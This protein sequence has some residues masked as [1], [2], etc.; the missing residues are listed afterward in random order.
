MGNL[1]GTASPGPIAD[2]VID[3]RYGMHWV[4]VSGLA[5]PE[6]LPTSIAAFTIDSPRIG[7]RFHGTGVEVNGWVVGR[8][9]P[10]QGIRAEREGGLGTLYPLDVQRDDVGADYPAFAHAGSSGFTAWSR[11]DVGT[12]DWHLAV[13]AVLANGST[14]TLAEI[15]GKAGISACDPRTDA[16]A[17]TAPDFIIVGA[18]RGG[19]TSLHAYLSAHPLVRTPSTKELHFFTDRFER[20]HSWYLS[21]FPA[22]LPPGI[23]TGEATPYALFHPL[24]PERARQIAPEAKLIALLRN[25]VDRAYSHYLL[26]RSRGFEPLEFSAALDAE[27]GRLAGEEAAILRCPTYLGAA[28][29]RYSYLARGDYAPQ[30]ERWLAHFPRDQMLVLRSE[31]LY[32]Q[33]RET[34]A[35]VAVFL[36]IES[37]LDTPFLAH[38]RTNGPPM[39]PA[40]RA[41]LSE[42]FAPRNAR[43]VQLMDWERGWD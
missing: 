18:Q 17:A 28:H 2:N 36:G 42:Y 37:G 38:N 7:D 12:N 4:E 10:V 5:L 39:I 31:D 8:E 43:L 32:E 34:F 27:A 1:L 6:P 41:R 14:V 40:I 3:P 11:N 35:R 29:K 23:L 30:L 13:K 20:G 24:A 21:Q 33:P 22:P 9:G 25:P 16:F 19:T 26:E 15:S